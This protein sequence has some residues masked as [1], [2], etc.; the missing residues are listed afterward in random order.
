[1]RAETSE[2]SFPSP[3][4][5]PLLTL[6][7]AIRELRPGD[8]KRGFPLRIRGVV[9]CVQPERQSFVLQDSSQGL[10]VN[11]TNQPIELPMLDDAVEVKGK[12]DEPG[13]AKLTQLTR[14]GQGTLPE[15]SHPTW[16]QLM[17]G[18]QDSQCVEV[19]GLVEGLVD[20]SN[21][22]TR[23]MLRSRAGLLK[24]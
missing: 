2:G 22:W 11:A 23:V 5:L 16:D 7:S 15:P 10:Y 12:T 19:R 3:G 18:S 20:R 14:L 4:D 1:S 24:V 17:N 6:A 21:G 13:L 9:T 8:A